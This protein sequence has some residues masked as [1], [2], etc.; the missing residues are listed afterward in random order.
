MKI[1]LTTEATGGASLRA[2]ARPGNSVAYNLGGILGA[3]LAPYIAQRLVIEG[4]LAWVGYY[5][6]TAAAISFLSVLTIRETK[7]KDL[8]SFDLEIGDDGEWSTRNNLGRQVEPLG[9]KK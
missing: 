5:L 7:G 1:L 2:C 3:S 4:G 6:S 9:G 8:S